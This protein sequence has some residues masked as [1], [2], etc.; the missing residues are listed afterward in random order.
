MLLKIYNRISNAI[1][2]HRYRRL[3]YSLF[4]HYAHKSEIASFALQQAD[5]AFFRLTGTDW[6]DWL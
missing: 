6:E 1:L 2:R 5:E 3:Y 4:W